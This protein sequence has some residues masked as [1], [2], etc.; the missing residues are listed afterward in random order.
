[1]SR[2]LILHAFPLQAARRYDLTA[3]TPNRRAAA[4]LGKTARSLEDLARETLNARGRS[5]A[6]AL[7]S[8]ALLAQAVHVVMVGDDPEGMAHRIEE[9]VRTLFRAGLDLDRLAAESGRA[10]DLAR[11]A[12][13][14]R[15]RLR[16][17]GKV[18]RGEAL[19]EA[20]RQ[21]PEQRRYL[22]YGYPRLDADALVFLNALCADG[23]VVV[24]PWAADA[25]FQENK[26]AA[27]WLRERGW[28]VQNDADARSETVGER[29]SSALFGSA[30]GKSDARALAYP[31]LDSE[32]RG[33]LGQVK[34]LLNAGKSPSSIVL[35]ARNDAAYGPVLLR[36]AWEYLVPVRALYAVPLRETRLGS[37][38]DQFCQVVLDGLAFEP[39]Y[40]LRSFS[41]A[42]EFLEKDRDAALRQHPSD[43]GAWSRLGLPE[44]LLSWPDEAPG[45]E[46]A[47][48]LEQ[49]LAHWDFRGSTGRW[50]Q[51]AIAF[52]YFQ[53]AVREWRTLVPDWATRKEAV[54][55]VRALLD[56][57]TVPAAP[58]RGGVEL[59]TPLSLFGS[60][61][62]YVFVLGASEG[63]LP[64]PVR[65][66]PVLDFH[67][68]RRLRSQDFV[69][70]S[71]AE[72]ARREWLSFW[73]LLQTCA[74]HVTFSYA[75]LGLEG[76]RESSPY[77]ARLGLK[78]QSI[79]APRAYSREEF[80]R[81]ALLHTAP[82]DDEVL[83]MA[84][85]A[86]GIESKRE[87]DS[88]PDEFDGVFGLA[89]P[90][91]DRVFTASEINKLGQCPFQWFAGTLLGLK[92]PDEAEDEI[93]PAARGSFYHEVL[94]A[95]VEKA[96]SQA[97][98]P[99][100]SGGLGLAVVDL[101]DAIL[102]SLEWAV[103][104]A[105]RKLDLDRMKAWKARR[106]EMLETMRRAILGA[107][108]L[109]DGAE[110][111]KTEETF[112]GAWNGLQVK[113]RVDRVDRTPDGLVVVDYKTGS[114]P[115][116]GAKDAEGKL[117]LDVQISL[118]VDV[119]LEHLFPGESRGRPY[120]Y[121][122]NKA[123]ELKLPDGRTDPLSLAALAEEIR[124][125]LSRGDLPVSPDA[126]QDAC[127]YCDFDAVCRRGPRLSWKGA[128]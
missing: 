41:L 116:K 81:A 86:H 88:E 108:F 11:V 112:R 69:L 77:L 70:E 60:R 49:V 20:A 127:K 76:E 1:M 52:N 61:Y 83:V 110:I 65:D 13:D 68:R 87:S 10:A 123:K 66:D 4:A 124:D 82:S 120:Y 106:L 103:D 14:Y 111:A 16:D 99:P 115:P 63:S 94:K 92:V 119:A 24:L 79:P 56:A 122:I 9:P 8:Q 39:A 78:A 58:G 12:L 95:A 101:R 54:R 53:Q 40:R 34:E 22:V 18:D 125:R 84:C 29:L 114:S 46:F 37:W 26:T 85:Q 28:D 80:R 3:L 6:G 62:E 55:Q 121:S 48:R 36:I 74:G 128:A 96:R 19:Q 57:V 21:G 109:R 102:S 38:I 27:E 51:E 31:N 100:N 89:V 33:V 72:A 2:T 71:A 64:A 117:T 118:Y 113:G 47:Q 91:E 43:S 15:Q 93:S 50:A 104:L 67:E 98:L 25:M 32:A 73:S 107:D 23:S 97:P 44:D 35:V 17:R 30:S 7:T 59:R 45:P 105:V 5:I 90:W 75:R 126:Q 42:P